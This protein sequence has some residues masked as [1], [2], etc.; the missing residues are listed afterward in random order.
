MKP[1]RFSREY[2]KQEE[3]FCKKVL[4]DFYECKKP[5]GHSE[6]ERLRN[7]VLNKRKKFKMLKEKYV[8]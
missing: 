5:N 8:I 6:K 2:L 3:I 1:I 4:D 7:L